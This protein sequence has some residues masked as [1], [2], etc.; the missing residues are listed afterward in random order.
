MD[1]AVENIQGYDDDNSKYLSLVGAINLVSNQLLLF[2][3]E[4]I[5]DYSKILYK[6]SNG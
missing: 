4:V 6:T 2:I 3:T 1:Q 5:T